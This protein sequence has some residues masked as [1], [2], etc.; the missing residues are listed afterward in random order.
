MFDVLSRIAAT[1][2]FK[3]SSHDWKSLLNVNAVKQAHVLGR[4]LKKLS[5]DLHFHEV[6]LCL[7]VSR[8]YQGSCQFAVHHVAELS[9]VNLLIAFARESHQMA[10][11]A[12]TSLYD[13]WSTDVQVPVRPHP[14]R[15]ED[16]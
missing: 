2:R 1:H 7:S 9:F 15:P 16:E 10:V 3:F 14:F 4:D 6:T 8:P 11:F 13:I 5:R 12:L